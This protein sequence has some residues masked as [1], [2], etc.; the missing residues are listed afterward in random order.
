MTKFKPL[1][2][3]GIFVS[4][5]RSL[6]LIDNTMVSRYVKV[7]EDAW[8][9]KSQEPLEAKEEDNFLFQS[10]STEKMRK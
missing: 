4:I 9:S 6:R 3:E 2:I 1:S 7:D 8:S 10:V 5:V